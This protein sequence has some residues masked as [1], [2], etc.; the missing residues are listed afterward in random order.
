MAAVLASG[1]TSIHIA[2]AEPHVVDLARCLVK[3]GARI[4]GAGS[5]EIEVEGVRVLRGVRHR[6]IP[7][8]IEA[9]TLAAA[10][11][12]TRG[13]G[14]IKG[15]RPNDCELPIL[16]MREA[17]VPVENQ[18]SKAGKWNILQ[19]EPRAAGERAIIKNQKLADLIIKPA[20]RLS[21]IPYPG[22]KTR[23]YP[24]FPSDLQAPFSVL[25]TQ[26]TGATLIHETLYEGRLK[27][28][29]EL[30]KMGANA[31]IMDP[32]RALVIGPTALYAREFQS[33]DLR[34][35]ATLMIAAL[36]AEGESVIHDAY[37]IDRGYERIEEKL[38][39]LG[40]E[41]KRVSNE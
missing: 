20:L 5:H 22:I 32:H 40:A 6:V 23:P 11:A 39:R 3:M 24:G 34:A 15:V 33:L 21:A 25:A 29:E 30:K 1:R 14:I 16:R 18:K 17:G 7:D 41:I 35:G 8:P 28:V 36:V 38:Q 2:A 9:M 19:R 31:V 13:R 10:L 27:H 26:L 12:A 37:T 4:K